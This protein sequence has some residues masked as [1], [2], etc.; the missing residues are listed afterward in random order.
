MVK[1]HNGRT[2][3]YETKAARGN[4]GGDQKE[5]SSVYFP[6]RGRA[7][8]ITEQ[9]SSTPI[10]FDITIKGGKVVVDCVAEGYNP[11]RDSITC[12]T[13]ALDLA[14]ASVNL[15]AFG[16]GVGASV[17]IDRSLDSSGNVRLLVLRDRPL[18]ALCTAFSADSESFDEVLDFVFRDLRLSRAIRDLVESIGGPH[19]IPTNCA[20]SIETIRSIMVPAHVPRKDGWAYMQ[21]H[22]RVTAD[23]LKIITD[24]GIGPRHGDI[25]YVPG[26]LTR[27]IADRSW[28]VMNRYLEYLKRCAKPLPLSEF[29]LLTG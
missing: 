23:Y 12:F 2:R 5:G 28:T 8:R 27:V 10:D 7:I 18:S 16:M 11:E 14:N 17:I 25:K 13:R 9:G 15:A 24:H 4:E 26:E 19:I 6:S 1:S 21:E 20:R 22:L 29:P 3:A